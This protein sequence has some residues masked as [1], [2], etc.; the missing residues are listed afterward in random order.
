V[1]HA[2]SCTDSTGAG[3]FVLRIPTAGGTQTVAGPFTFV[4]AD[5]GNF[6]T[7]DLTGTLTVPA[8]TGDCVNTPITHTTSIFTV[9]VT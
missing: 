7:G 8:V 5:I 4:D 1:A 3:T 2:T 6:V 9:H